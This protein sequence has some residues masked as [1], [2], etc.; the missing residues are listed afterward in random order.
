MA[1]W[2]LPSVLDISGERALV[3]FRSIKTLKA[4]QKRLFL[5]NS[6]L[7]AA[8]KTPTI[9]LSITRLTEFIFRVERKNIY[10]IPTLLLDWGLALF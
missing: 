10:Y 2:D 8:P 4:N 7:L 3:K 9:Y 6:S 1:T 5:N